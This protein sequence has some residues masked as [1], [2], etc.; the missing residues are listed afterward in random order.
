M[1]IGVVVD[2]VAEYESLGQLFPRLSAASGHSYLRVVK[3]DIQPKA[4]LPTIARACKDAVVQLEARGANLVLIL[5]DREDRPECPGEISEGVARR[6][7]TLVHCR[8]S[9]V[10]KDRAYE[11]WLVADLGAF[12]G[13]RTRY[14]V[15]PR[16]HRQLEPN[17][18]D[19]ADALQIIKTIVQG[20]YDK[21]D[22]SKAIMEHAAPEAISRHSRSFRKFLRE[23][24]HPW[25]AAQSLLPG[26]S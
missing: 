12:S 5:F 15:A 24:R 1:R 16:H 18:A 21:V 13:H 20:D 6:L 19:Q 3:A 7:A 11:N 14:V 4:P 9:V 8:V 26:H 10:V 17:K 22:D 2:G 25:Y 23:A